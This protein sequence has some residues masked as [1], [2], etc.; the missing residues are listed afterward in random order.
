MIPTAFLL[1]LM[2]NICRYRF[3]PPDASILHDAVRRRMSRGIEADKLANQLRRRSRLD[4]YQIYNRF[5]AK[6]GA[7]IQVVL[8]D[9]ADAHEMIKNVSEFGED[10]WSS[11]ESRFADRLITLLFLFFQLILWRNPTGTWRTLT[12]FGVVTT[13]VTLA[14]AHFVWKMFF[15]FIGFTFFCLM[16]SLS[17]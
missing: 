14:P 2:F 6:Y 10:D 17:Y 5:T 11:Q 12:L 1:Y 15:F 4:V 7:D 8:G 9:V 13:F 3:F 16:V